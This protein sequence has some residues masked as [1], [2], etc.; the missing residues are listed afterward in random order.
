MVNEGIGIIRNFMLGFDSSQ[1]FCFL[2][3]SINDSSK[4]A[5]EMLGTQKCNSDAN[6]EIHA[7]Q[8]TKKKK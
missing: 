3:S 4:F 7:K 1:Q 5:V 6:A 8:G 2:N